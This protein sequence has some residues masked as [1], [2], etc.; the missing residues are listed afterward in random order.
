MPRAKIEQ[1]VLSALSKNIFTANFIEDNYQELKS[2]LT[3]EKNKNAL[4]KANLQRKWNN[5]DSQVSSLISEI[6]NQKLGTSAMIQRHLKV[7]EEKLNDI[8]PSIDALDKKTSLPIMR[9]S[10]NQIESFVSSCNKVLLGGNT[11]ATKALMLALVKDITVYEDN[12]EIRGGHLLRLANV[13]NNKAGNPEGVP[14]L[15]SI[16]R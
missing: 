2:L 14:S 15:I 9:F 13:A 16:W 11:E 1:A 10:R 5:V 12:V 8:E 3:A 4:E 6:A 7:Y